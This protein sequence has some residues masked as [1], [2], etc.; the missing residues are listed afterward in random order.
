MLYNSKITN[1]NVALWHQ[2][3]NLRNNKKLAFVRLRIN[4]R[5]MA[6]VDLLSIFSN[7]KSVLMICPSCLSVSPGISLWIPEPVFIKLGITTE[8]ISTVYFTNPSQRVSVSVFVYLF[9]L[10]GNS[11]VNTFPRQRIYATVDEFLDGLW[12]LICVSFSR[13]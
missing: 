2:P 5:I 4:K 9:S 12:H 8:R 13:C 3:R 11:S 7:N 1:G 6:L 10:L